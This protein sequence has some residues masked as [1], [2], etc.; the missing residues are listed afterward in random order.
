MYIPRV[1]ATA[2]AV[3]AVAVLETVD[4]WLRTIHTKDKV[5]PIV[6]TIFCPQ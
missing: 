2:T 4:A 6:K 5:D 1:L 3:E